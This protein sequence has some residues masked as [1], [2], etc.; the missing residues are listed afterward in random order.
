MV[1]A[2]PPSASSRRRVVELIEAG[3]V[4]VDGRLARKGDRVARRRRDRAGPGPGDPRRPA[5]HPRPRRR[6]PA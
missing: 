5:G 3:G 6:R 2:R 4:R 1:A